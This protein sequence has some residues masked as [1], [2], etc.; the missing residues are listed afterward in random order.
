MLGKLE[1]KVD[2]NFPKLFFMVECLAGEENIH[3]IW[4]YINLRIARDRKKYD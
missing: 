1:G 3:E 2:D 4:H